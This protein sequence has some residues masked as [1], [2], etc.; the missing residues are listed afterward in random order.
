MYPSVGISSEITGYGIQLHVV[1]SVKI[2]G[3]GE[4]VSLCI[5][6]N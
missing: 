1:F 5:C 4:R 2:K 6:K 3:V